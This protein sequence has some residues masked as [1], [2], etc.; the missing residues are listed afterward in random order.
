MVLLEQYITVGII[1]GC[2]VG[3]IL[4]RKTFMWMLPGLIYA[5]IPLT[6]IIDLFEI[7]FAEIFNL[8]IGAFD[9]IEDIIK[10]LD[11]KIHTHLQ[12]F[13]SIHLTSV[14]QVRNWLH[15]IQTQ[16]NDYTDA[17]SIIIN[18]IKHATY[19]DVCPAIRYIKPINVLYKPAA[20]V[21]EAFLY[22]GSADPND[23]F[24]MTDTNCKD[25]GPNTTVNLTCTVLGTGYIFIEI[26]FPL[27]III[28]TLQLCGVDIIIILFTIIEL[29]YL[30]VDIAFHY[31]NKLS[32][33]LLL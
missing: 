3:G 1:I 2:G 14:S 31:I 23:N 12:N 19:K 17:Y 25:N 28:I 33:G 6:A 29:T 4:F 22:F 21:G 24:G 32:G 9:V 7:G 15:M 5:C 27:F 16:C 10:A 26:L 11:P 13:I 18:G 20:A 8:I 30:Y